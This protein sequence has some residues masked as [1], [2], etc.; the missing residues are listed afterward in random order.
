MSADESAICRP[1]RPADRSAVRHICNETGHLGDP[2]DPYFSDRDLFADVH[3]LYYTDVESGASYVIEDE[4]EVIGYLL[5]CLD[6]TKHGRWVAATLQ[7]RILFKALAHADLI[8]P[9]TAPMAWR[10]IADWNREKP[11]FGETDEDHPA[12]LHINLLPSGRGRGLGGLL[13]STYLERLISEG[14]PGLFLETT[15]ENENAVAFF[16]S[17]GFV[18]VSTAPSPGVRASDGSRLHTLMMTRDVPSR[19][20]SDP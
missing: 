18:A 19:N 9:G 15:V 16:R 20:V 8:R 1:Y 14:I 12:H 17:Q 4:G 6:S 3:S 7:R 2:I 10:L 11:V 5:G 13:V